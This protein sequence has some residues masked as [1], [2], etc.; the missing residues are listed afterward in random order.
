MMKTW[1]NSYSLLVIMFNGKRNGVK[2]DL[3]VLNCEY[4][5]YAESENIHVRVLEND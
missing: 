3:W 1:Q 5:E 2:S 4:S